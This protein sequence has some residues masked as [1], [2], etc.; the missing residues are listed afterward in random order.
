[1][2][3]LWDLL[4]EMI[5]KRWVRYLA[6]GGF[7]VIGILLGVQSL[8]GVQL[9][10][11]KGTI[12]SVE[13]KVDSQTGDYQ[14][15]LISLDGQT[16][17]YSL[18]V[19]EFTPGLSQDAVKEGQRVVLWYTQIP[20][21]DPDVLAIQIF[22]TNGTPTKYVTNAYSDPVGT[23]RG[24][25]ITSVIFVFLGILSFVS[26]LWLPVRRES[27]VPATSQSTLGNRNA[28]RTS[29]GDMVLGPA[30]RPPDDA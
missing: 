25:L 9:H 21:F 30:P 14:E 11:A 8:L 20:L 10:M 2:K 29:Y 1:M 13:V 15:H 26:A 19:N 27:G 17:H 5:D 22:G 7:C 23:V 18:E 28:S 16:T 6:G 24:N 3:T 12:R 4:N